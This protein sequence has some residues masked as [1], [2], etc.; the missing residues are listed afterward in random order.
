MY[1]WAIGKKKNL[2]K[3]HGRKITTRWWLN[4]PSAKICSSNWIISPIFRVK[5]K[6][7]WNHHLEH[8]CKRCKFI[9]WSPTISLND[10]KA[11]LTNNH[12]SQAVTNRIGESTLPTPFLEA[13]QL[14]LEPSPVPARIDENITKNGGFF[15][16]LSGYMIIY[17]I[18]SMYGISTYMNGKF[19]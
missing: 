13:H 18:G 12:E 14:E 2:T 10:V 5:I 7:I 8:H 9:S 3:A 6:N 4:H 15:V 16:R 11:K 1:Y 17:P 19:R